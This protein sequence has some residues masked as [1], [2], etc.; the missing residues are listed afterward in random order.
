MTTASVT[1]S[2]FGDEIAPALEDQ[3]K[4]LNE[5]N[6]S[7]LECRTAWGTN[8]LKLT[9]DQARQVRALCDDAGITVRC[10]GSPIG[11]SPLADPIENEL[12]N[13]DRLIE[14]GHL[15][16]TRN[17]RIFSFYP[18][19]IRTN[20]H[21]D[22]YVPEVIDRL[23]RLTEKAAAA[24]FVLL[25]ENEKD[26]VG[27]TPERCQALVSGVNSPNLRLI[28]DPAN[29]VQVGVADQV[30]R[31]WDLMGP[32]IGYIHI[33]DA[34]LADRSVTAAG[35]GDGQVPQLLAHLKAV[36][37]SGVLALEPHL[38]VAGHSTGFSGVEGMTIAVN[39]LR[40]VMAEVG[41][42]ETTA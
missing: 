42:P 33:K 8:V 25:H 24:D 15:F 10:I 41:L 18:A 7:G 16:G 13:L 2:A 40:K 23:G 27:D 20:A 5:L 34:R 22:Q 4:L 31:F 36:G 9:D 11:K 35:E 12:G 6:V 17:I 3:L 14:I 30:D 21:Y 37:Y 19:D 29:F 26:I 1:L 28:W 32:L 38:K 39:A